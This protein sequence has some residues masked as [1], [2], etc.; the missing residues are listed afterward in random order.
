MC[1]VVEILNAKPSKQKRQ[2]V[3][4]QADDKACPPGSD[5]CYGLKMFLQNQSWPSSPPDRARVSKTQDLGTLVLW[6]SCQW[7][8]C[9][10]HT[11]KQL[12]SFLQAAFLPLLS[13]HCIAIGVCFSDFPSSVKFSFK[14]NLQTAQSKTAETTQNHFS[15][16]IAEI[17]KKN[18]AQ[19]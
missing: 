7:M 19:D 10:G 1:R 12:L 16:N 13:N 18:Q 4:L 6:R 5:R 8:C 3:P 15:E 2:K 11:G 17:R 14:T 9:P